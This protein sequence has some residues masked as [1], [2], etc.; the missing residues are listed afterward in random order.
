MDDVG[1]ASGRVEIES[2]AR[3]RDGLASFWK[4]RL[5]LPRVPGRAVRDAV[6]LTVLTVVAVTVRLPGL[7]S[8]GLYRDD[9]WPALA[10]K[11]GWLRSMRLGVTIPGFEV[12]VRSWFGVL[13]STPWVQLPV[14]VASVAS[15]VLAYVLARRLRCGTAGAAVAAGVLALSPISVLYATRLKQ[16]AFDALGTLLL[17]AAALA[18]ARRPESRARWLVLLLLAV[19]TSWF[20]ASLLPIGA[21]ALGYC[22]LQG[23]KAGVRRMALAIAATFA[24]F[25]VIYAAVVLRSVPRPLTDTWQENYI[26]TGTLREFVKSTVHVLDAF[27]AGI[28]YRHGPTGP[29]LLL[30]IAAGAVWYRRRIGLLLLAPLLLALLG[31][32][33]QRAPL[34]GGRIDLYLYPCVALSAGMASQKLLDLGGSRLPALL[35]EAGVLAA[36]VAF[37]ITG[38]REHMAVNPYPAA[39]IGP[40]MA[41]VRHHLEPGDAVIVSPFSR[42]PY[43]LYV[44]RHPVLVLSRQYATGF[45]VRSTEPDVL[46]MPAEYFEHGY[47]PQAPVAF[48]LGRNRVWYISTD[49]PASDTPPSIQAYEYEPE[50]ALI[51]NGFRIEQRLE[52]HGVH[53]HLLVRLP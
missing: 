27:A 24:L 45:T 31:A 32:L 13:R 53:A 44:D 36:V 4:E 40:L 52:G 19:G 23:W 11:T 25:S 22:L 48:T 39:D 9:A 2:V 41:Q 51:S 14:L 8:H 38:A 1:A 33:L 5:G 10:T 12:F 29:I 20:S 16:Y 34:G 26:H 49:T 46:I 15:V 17:I 6:A 28:F 18:V 7:T 37:A 30:L 35:A 3:P 47:D 21:T 42:Y 43:A 50:E